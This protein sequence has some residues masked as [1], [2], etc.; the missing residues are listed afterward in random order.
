[1]K[2][3]SKN[4]QLHFQNAESNDKVG[5]KIKNWGRV[6]KCQLGTS[7]IAIGTNFSIIPWVHFFDFWLIQIYFC[8]I[9]FTSFVVTDFL[10]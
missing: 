8:K 4:F 3:V 7:T 1:M 5:K 10:S 9:K 2:I 6:P